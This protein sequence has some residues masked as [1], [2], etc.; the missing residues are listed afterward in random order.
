MAVNGTM[1]DQRGQVM[2]KTEGMKRGAAGV[3]DVAMGAGRETL[4]LIQMQGV[5]NAIGGNQGQRITVLGDMQGDPG[6]GVKAVLRGMPH[7]TGGVTEI[8]EEK[9][10]AETMTVVQTGVTIGT[11]KEATEIEN[12]HEGRAESISEEYS[13]RVL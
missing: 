4:V 8:G 9:K 2:I 11:E 6:T 5:P 1:V 12:E 10:E 3:S 7:D 13:L